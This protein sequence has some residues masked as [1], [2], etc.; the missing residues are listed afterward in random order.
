M[1]DLLHDR[2]DPDA[3]EVGVLPASFMSREVVAPLIAGESA[4]Q[5]AERARALA[6]AICT[7]PLDLRERSQLRVGESLERV[8]YVS[9]APEQTWLGWLLHLMQAPRPFCLSVHVQATDRYRERM[10]QKRRYKRLYGVNRGVEQHGRPLDP[11]A[12]VAEE[13]A[14]ELNDELATSAGAGIYRVS[15]YAAIREPGPDPDPESLRELCESAG[16]EATMACDAR[17]QH[18]PFAQGRL[19]RSTLPLGR[20]VA[21]RRRKYVTR[22]VGDTFPLV[23]TSCGSPE[24]IPLGYA[25]PGR[26]LERLDPFDPA[27]PNHLLLV[28]GMSG[29]GKT[30]AAIILLDPRARAGRERVHHRPRRPLRVPRLP[31]PRRRVGAGRRRGARDQLVGRRGPRE[32]RR[33]EDRLS[34]RAARAAAGRAPRRPRLLRPHGP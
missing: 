1:L 30:M 32:R 15:I 33:G 5:A 20:D 4:E 22:N 8:L 18:G 9:L 27:H 17:I 13:E 34:A 26:T 29:A 2:F 28:N 16:R 6:R 3:Q 12:R 21:R 24:G 19:W 10:A 25:L 7:A 31:D 14:A 11:D 23:G